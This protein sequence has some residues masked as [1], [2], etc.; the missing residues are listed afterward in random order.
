MIAVVVSEHPAAIDIEEIKKRDVT[1][2]DRYPEAYYHL[3]TRE[4]ESQK[5]E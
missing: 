2:L 5:W 1:L 4:E 3:L